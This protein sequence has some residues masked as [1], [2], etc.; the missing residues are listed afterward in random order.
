[1]K[2]LYKTTRDYLI[3]SVSILFFTG[4]TLFMILQKAVGDEMNEQLELEADEIFVNARKGNFIAAPLISINKVSTK[5]PI[6]IIFGDSMLY[7]RIQKEYEQYHY[8]RETQRIG[9]DHYQ[10][11]VMTSHIGWDQYYLTILYIFL[12]TAFLLTGSGVLINYFSNKKIWTP[13]FKNLKSVQGFSVSASAELKLDQSNIDEFKELNLTLEDLTR[14]SRKEYLLLR[15]FT[16]NAS[17]EIQT[18]L[19]IVQSKLDRMSQ[20]EISQ[21]MADYIIQAQSGVDRLV[22]LNKS[23]LLL[24]KLDNNIFKDRQEIQV[25]EIVEYQIRIM[26]DLFQSKAIILTDHI[27]PTTAFSDKYLLETLVYNLLSNALRYTP[28]NGEV[29]INLKNEMLSISNNGPQLDFPEEQIFERF[30]KSQQ[31]VTSTGLGLAISREICLL[32]HWELA[33]EF[34]ENCHAFAVKFSS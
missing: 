25:H 13:F 1:M 19:S 3:A 28:V 7:D 14:R 5:T 9:P 12:L 8:I 30:I 20:L 16:E 21:Q 22:K 4:I 33:Y 11:V 23:L 27:L 6:G 34:K 10:A 29:S 24:A 17:H 15:E 26:E 18:P 2:L 31:H 32:N